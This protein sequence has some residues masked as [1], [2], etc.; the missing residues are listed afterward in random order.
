MY[1]Y[2]IF[3]IHSAGDGH[4][5]CLMIHFCTNTSKESCYHNDLRLV[6]NQ[7]LYLALVPSVPC[8]LFHLQ[9]MDFPFALNHHSSLNILEMVSH[10]WV[11]GCLPVF[12]ILCCG[13]TWGCLRDCCPRGMVTTCLEKWEE[14]WATMKAHNPATSLHGWGRIGT[15]KDTAIQNSPSLW[16]QWMRQP[17]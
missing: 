3:C 1:L 10:S 12:W 7:A 17:L 5:G 16:V 11:P 4:L 2:H 9:V 15:M 14:M 13:P 8:S 6:L